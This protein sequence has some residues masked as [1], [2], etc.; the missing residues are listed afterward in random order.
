MPV[1]M[2]AGNGND[3][4]DFINMFNGSNRKSSSPPPQPQTSSQSGPSSSALLLSSIISLSSLFTS[5]SM[6]AFMSHLYQDAT[7]L[8]KSITPFSMDMTIP[9]S[10]VPHIL[11]I[12]LHIPS[13]SS[14]SSPMLEKT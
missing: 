12:P 13:F 6:T 7:C 3:L 2:E 10:I 1:T 14:V 5:S 9:S 4:H 11:K 8:P